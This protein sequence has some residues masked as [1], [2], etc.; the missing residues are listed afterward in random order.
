MINQI[1]TFDGYVDK[2]KNDSKIVRDRSGTGRTTSTPADLVD[3]HERRYVSFKDRLGDTFRWK[4]ENVSTND[5][6][7]VLTGCP[8]VKEAVVYGV[9][10]P[11]ADGRAGMAALVVDEAAFD[12]DRF[13]E[14]VCEKLPGYSRPLFVRFEKRLTLTASFKY[15]KTHLK[16]DGY[17]PAKC[18][19]EVRFLDGSKYVPLTPELIGKLERAEVRL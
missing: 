5:V 9:Q 7:E 8:G 2:S 10:V 12:L 15:V 1:N 3:L 4:A 14:H 16:E 18:K 17:D 13:A 6:Q 11:H 19:G